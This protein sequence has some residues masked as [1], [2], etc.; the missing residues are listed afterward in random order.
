ML[1]FMLG[2]FSLGKFVIP[3]LKPTI[4]Q[5]DPRWIGAWWLGETGGAG[6]WWLGETGG[7]DPGAWLGETGA[8]IRERGAHTQWPQSHLGSTFRNWSR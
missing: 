2:S 6:A 5:R 3:S 7:A 4:S 1:G 8:P